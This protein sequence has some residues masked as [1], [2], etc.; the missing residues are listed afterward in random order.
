MPETPAFAR[1]ANPDREA[2]EVRARLPLE[3]IAVLDAIAFDEG[4]DRTKVVIQAC[5]AYAARH[6]RRATLIL[7]AC[8]G[9]P[10]PVD[11]T[12]E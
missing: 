6:H 3:V 2:A 12:E 10:S 8:R 11:S 5:Q 9:Y 7:N 4:S 1:P